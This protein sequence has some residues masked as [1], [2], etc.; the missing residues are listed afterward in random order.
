MC[1]LFDAIDKT[2][3]DSRKGAVTALRAAHLQHLRNS[4]TMP[5]E[6]LQSI[7]KNHTWTDKTANGLTKMIVAFLDYTGHYANR[8]NT[9]GQAQVSEVGR[10]D[11]ITGKLETTKRITGYR[12]STTK[13]GTPDIDAIISG[14]PAKIEVKIGKDRMSKDQKKQKDKIERAGGMYYI[15]K[16]FLGFYTWYLQITKQK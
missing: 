7:A 2:I 3:D 11:V 1:S 16:D 4:S 8:I 10:Y 15:A 6:E 5:D 13:K 12:K 14:K 9:Q